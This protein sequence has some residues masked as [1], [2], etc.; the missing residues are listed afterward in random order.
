MR[1]RAFCARMKR[2]GRL[3]IASA[4]VG[5]FLLLF[6]T[7]CPIVKTEQNASAYIDANKYGLTVVYQPTIKI[8]ANVVDGDAFVIAKDTIKTTTSSPSGYSLYISSS[9]DSNILQATDFPEAD[10]TKF[11]ALN[12]TAESPVALNSSEKSAWGYAIPGFAGFD[13]TYSVDN[14]SKTSR[15]AALPVAGD[16]ELIHVHEGTADEVPIEVYYGFRVNADQQTGNYDI[17]IAYT[18][19]VEITPEEEGTLDVDPNLLLADYED[20]RI[21]IRTSTNNTNL[22]AKVDGPISVRLVGNPGVDY[23]YAEDYYREYYG[24]TP[25]DY[26][27][28]YIFDCKDPEVTSTEPL[29]VVCTVEAGHKG[30]LYDVHVEIPSIGRSYHGIQKLTIQEDPGQFIAYFDANGGYD[31]PNP[32]A[33]TPYTDYDSPYAYLYFPQYS[34]LRDGYRFLGWSTCKDYDYNDGWVD[35]CSFFDFTASYPGSRT[36]G[37]GY[38]THYTYLYEPETTFYAVWERIEVNLNFDYN[39]GDGNLGTITSY[40]NYFTLPTT[41]LP[42][43]D[44]YEFVGWSNDPYTHD[45]IYRYDKQTNSYLSCTEYEYDMY[46]GEREYVGTC[47]EGYT[48]FSYEDFTLYAIWNRPTLTN[49]SDAVYMQDMND[50]IL[51]SMEEEKQ[52]QLV[53]SRDGKK[54]WVAK[55]KDGN[56]WM[57][58]NLDYDVH[59]NTDE[60]GYLVAGAGESDLGGTSKISENQWGLRYYHRNYLEGGDYYIDSDGN[61]Q[62]TDGLAEDSELWHY[63]VGDY[64]TSELSR[65]DWGSICPRGWRL[66]A[67][68][69]GSETPFLASYS[70]L[71][72]IYNYNLNYSVSETGAGL[73]FAE[74]PFYFAKAGY[75]QPDGNTPVLL[76]Q[77]QSGHYLSS[78][79]QGGLEFNNDWYSI[80][81]YKSESN[82]Y[83]VRCVSWKDYTIHYDMNYEGGEVYS[84]TSRNSNPPAWN[85]DGFSGMSGLPQRDG[86]DFIGWA[87]DKDATVPDFAFDYYGNIQPY[88]VD[89]AMNG[90]DE[91]TLYALWEDRSVLY[92][93]NA[94]RWSTELEVG[95]EI[96]VIDRRD[97]KTYLVSRL[98]DGLVWMTQNLDFDLDKDVTYSRRTTM[99]RGELQSNR[100]TIKGYDNLLTEWQDDVNYDYSFDPGDYYY[101]GSDDPDAEE[102]NYM[103]ESCEHF[104]TTPFENGEHGHVGNYYNYATIIAQSA[105]WISNNDNQGWNFCPYGWEVTSGKSWRYD[106]DGNWDVLEGFYKDLSL[107]KTPL[108][109]VRAGYVDSTGLHGASK[110]GYY[111]SDTSMTA[112]TFATTKFDTEFTQDV[113]LSRGAGVSVRCYLSYYYDPYY[114]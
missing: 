107:T 13:Q 45:P 114:Y 26:D 53:D 21:S 106:G 84:E 96:E 93:Q 29:T 100:S 42:T 91:L 101:D 61:L 23:R 3:L 97:G 20:T 62:S 102:C 34:P 4:N 109:G 77:G 35:G 98:E 80:F 94:S 52:Y 67:Y 14:P 17:N 88:Y 1:E 72:K 30:G 51:K 90:G 11:L 82:A 111:G 64:Y 89:I 40:N 12:G 31:A 69:N 50:A 54:Y 36:G 28:E 110:E 57:T 56:V 38:Y 85:R 60:Y 37:F 87:Y 66:P 41:N 78:Q 74:S 46:N 24:M 7:F 68:E 6:L 92:M 71:F 32:I 79:L 65:F 16:A 63:Q 59:T 70:N 48:L 105:M 83:S 95:E 8:D 103:T 58:Q 5:L 113:E 108:Y 99:S 73:S 112:T 33:L 86:Y 49:I 2:F 75:V 104:S 18:S 76:E 44:E 15:F 19:I 81:A 10:N 43:R 9:S 25:E 22:G 27:P 55:M 39:G 47:N